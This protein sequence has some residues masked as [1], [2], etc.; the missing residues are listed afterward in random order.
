MQ[1]LSFPMKYQAVEPSVKENILA[2]QESHNC[3]GVSLAN[4]DGYHK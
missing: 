2:F 4:A 1:S 3:F